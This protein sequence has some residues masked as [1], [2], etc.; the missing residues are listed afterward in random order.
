MERSVGSWWNAHPSGQ[1]FAAGADGDFRNPLVGRASG[2]GIDDPSRRRFGLVSGGHMVERACGNR[3]AD[4]VMGSTGHT[5]LG[6][7]RASRRPRRDGHGLRSEL[8]SGSGDECCLS[9][10]LRRR[11]IRTV[12]VGRRW[13]VLAEYRGFADRSGV[14]VPRRC[15]FSERLT[16][17]RGRGVRLHPCRLRG[18][19][20][21]FGL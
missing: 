18:R 12:S 2:V 21:G 1:L 15:H 8:R 4:C 6:K 11:R 16:E 5:S 9:L 14:R 3:R 10:R 7:V 17:W 20:G 13:V 19:N